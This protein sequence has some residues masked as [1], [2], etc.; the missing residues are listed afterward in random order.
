[1]GIHVNIDLIINTV[2]YNSKNAEAQDKKH[3]DNALS[4][5]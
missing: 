2:K 3:Q 5:A 4:L 1:M